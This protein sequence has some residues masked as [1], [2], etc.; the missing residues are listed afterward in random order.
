MKRHLKP[1]FVLCANVNWRLKSDNY[2][3]I[4][5]RDGKYGSFGGVFVNIETEREKG[6]EH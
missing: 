2:S 6:S 1:E 5:S 3:P 4:K